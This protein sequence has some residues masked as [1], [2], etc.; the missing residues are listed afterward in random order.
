MHIFGRWAA[1]DRI[2]GKDK[3][4]ARLNGESASMSSGNRA[5]VTGGGAGFSQN[6]KT[7]SPTA[8]SKIGDGY[9]LS[10]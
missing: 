4:A 2:G 10:G 9:C 3:N 1:D 5:I 8:P 7:G 6:Q